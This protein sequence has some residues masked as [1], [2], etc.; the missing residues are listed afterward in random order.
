MCSMSLTVVVMERSKMVTMRFSISSGGKAAV[1]PDDADDRNID[2]G[3][4]I[5]RHGD[6]G[7]RAQDGNEQG[8]DDEGIRAAQ[9]ES[10]YPHF[11]S[12][13]P[14]TRLALV[15]WIVIYMILERRLLRMTQAEHGLLALWSHGKSG[16]GGVPRPAGLLQ[17]VSVLVR[18]QTELL[19]LSRQVRSQG[20]GRRS[21][22]G[23]D[24]RFH[25][26]AVLPFF[27]RHRLCQTSQLRF[28]RLAHRPRRFRQNRIYKIISS[29]VPIHPGSM[30]T[31]ATIPFALRNSPPA[32]PF[33]VS[34]S[35]STANAAAAARFHRGDRHLRTAFPR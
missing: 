12:T 28:G 22:P 4:D 24:H 20:F 14:A 34:R 27:F 2:I 13:L 15:S 3:E 23:G 7:R 32:P 16:P 1:A 33:L 17:Q 30:L 6:D 21:H 10:D 9:G 35:G 26:H 5:D 19:H 8:H 11:G 25:T 31:Q 29:V 18:I